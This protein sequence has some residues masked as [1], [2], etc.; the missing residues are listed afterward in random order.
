VPALAAA[1]ARVLADREL[2]A[3]LGASAQAAVARRHSP[4]AAIDR[5]GRIYA[6]LGLAPGEAR[7]PSLG[8]AP[9]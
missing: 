1:L 8:A 9:T 7:A 5:I 3:R 6:S 4:A 2:A